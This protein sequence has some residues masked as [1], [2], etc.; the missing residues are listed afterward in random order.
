MEQ[1]SEILNDKYN[2]TIIYES[3]LI[4]LIYIFV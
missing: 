3:Q 2:E 1:F 4:F